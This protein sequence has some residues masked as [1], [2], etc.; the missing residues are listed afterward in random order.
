MRYFPID[1][2]AKVAACKKSLT[3]VRCKIQ[4]IISAPLAR[5]ISALVRVAAVFSAAIVLIPMI[6][7]QCRAKVPTVVRTRRSDAT[8]ISCRAIGKNFHLSY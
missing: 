4:P 2:S 1:D 3:R 6:V 7:L 5:V 8:G